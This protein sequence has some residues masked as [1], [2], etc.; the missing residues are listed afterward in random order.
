MA[1]TRNVNGVLAVS[2]STTNKKASTAS[3][4]AGV[5]MSPKPGVQ[6]LRLIIRRLPPGLSQAE[7][8]D[9]LGS[10]WR[11][12][13]GKV[14]WFAYKDGKVSKEYAG[15]GMERDLTDQVADLRNLQ[16]LRERIYESR[17]RVCLTH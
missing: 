5:N 3:A 11:V 9:V 4:G 6:R 2:A 8:E 16:D 14:D 13:G 15:S 12:G 7:F 10:E 1:S 17:T